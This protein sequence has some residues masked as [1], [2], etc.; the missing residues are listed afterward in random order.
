MPAQD[1]SLFTRDYQAKGIKNGTDS[2]CRFCDKVV[3]LSWCLTMNP[4][5]YLQRHDRVGQYIHWKICKN[6]RVPT[7]F[8][9]IFLGYLGEFRRVLSDFLRYFISRVR[10]NK[11]K[12]RTFPSS[13]KYGTSCSNLNCDNTD[14]GIESHLL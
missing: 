13:Q 1:Q 9:V 5:E 10:N 6:Y 12:F 3:V 14:T 11:A 4:N 2:K 7:N 8:S